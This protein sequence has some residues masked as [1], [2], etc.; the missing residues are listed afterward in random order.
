M[1]KELLKGQALGHIH[2]GAGTVVGIK[3][4]DRHALTIIEMKDGRR[5]KRDGSLKIISY[6]DE[7]DF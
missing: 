1:F 3:Q 6:L 4:S 5:F 2:H 7:R